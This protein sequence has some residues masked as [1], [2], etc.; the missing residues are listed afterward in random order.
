MADVYRLHERREQLLGLERFAEKKVDNLLDGI[1]ASKQQPLERLLVGL[2][3]RHLGPSV[4]KLLAGHFQHMDGIVAASESDI[5]EID[6]VGP[7]IAEAVRSWID[8]PR[9]RQLVDDLASL[10]VRMDTDLEEAVAGEQPLE[11]WSVVVT[12]TLKGFSRSQAKEALETRGAKVT[13]SVSK[14]TSLVVVGDNPGSKRDK[15]DELGVPIVDEAAF[16]RLLDT[17]TV[18]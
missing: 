9:N 3:I 18:A 2:N 16:V 1:E 6:G 5:A 17:G 12:G 10:G 15:A 13:A 8:V 14:K 11:G 7:K 4:A